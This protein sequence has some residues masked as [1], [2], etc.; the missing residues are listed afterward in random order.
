[1]LTSVGLN[2]PDDLELQPGPD[3]LRER[4]TPD[5]LP[6]GTFL[7]CGTTTPDTR[8]VFVL[9]VQLGK[10][11]AKHYTWPLYVVVLRRRL[12]CPATLVVFTDS[13][14]VARW[15]IRPIDVGSGM[16]MRPLVIGPQQVPC[17]LSWEQCRNTPAL[18]VLAVVAHGRG[19]E[20]MRIGRRAL[21]SIEPM[22][23][24]GDERVILYVDVIHTYLDRTVLDE[25][26]ENEMSFGYQPISPYFKRLRAEGLAE[27]MVRMLERLLDHRGL[28]PSDHQRRRVVACKDPMLLQRWFDRAFRAT[29]MAE[30]FED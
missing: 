29:S 16:V 10:D 25:I 30:V 2:V 26:L 7:A 18:A 12:R 14:E 19:P 22:V 21:D 5:F 1:M 20:A 4:G 3:A 17:D 27:G 6:D 24:R 11:G 23:A 8:H 15:A 13:D 9:E 28:Q